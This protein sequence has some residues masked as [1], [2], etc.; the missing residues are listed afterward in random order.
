MKQII[1]LFKINVT[2][3]RLWEGF[4][5]YKLKGIKTKLLHSVAYTSART[6]GERVFWK[7]S[8]GG[9]AYA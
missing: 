4:K 5:N 7:H 9:I 3:F 2:N 8:Y 1:T 6:A